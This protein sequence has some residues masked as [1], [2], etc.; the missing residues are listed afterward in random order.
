LS[1]L[2]IRHTGDCSPRHRQPAGLDGH[3]DSLTKLMPG[4]MI[5]V[6][7][8]PAMG[9]SAFALGVATANARTGAPTLVHGLEMGR[10]EASNRILSARARVA[11]HHIRDG[12]DGLTQDDWDR[13]DRYAPELKDLPL[14]LPAARSQRRRGAW[15]CAR[16]SWP[17]IAT[18]WARGSRALISR[19]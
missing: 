7:A 17:C 19:P 9:K 1:K 6:A 4:Q 5:V 18:C 11:F 13:L 8:H 16:T 14:S 12:V 3:L 2:I 15:H 10:A